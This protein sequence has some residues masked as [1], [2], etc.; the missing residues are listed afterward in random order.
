[1]EKP[2]LLS[3]LNVGEYYTYTDD[4]FGN[5]PKSDEYR[6]VEVYGQVVGSAPLLEKPK[7]IPVRYGKK[8][9]R[10]NSGVVFTDDQGEMKRV[11]LTTDMPV[12]RKKGE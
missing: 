6:V 1:M 8:D 12:Y 10:P 7:C 3:T 11:S 2:V 4:G 9:Y 5:D